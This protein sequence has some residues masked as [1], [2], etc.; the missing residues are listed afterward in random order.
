MELRKYILKICVSSQSR[1]LSCG[2]VFN[3]KAIVLC[4]GLW[5]VVSALRQFS[6]EKRHDRESHTFCLFYC[7]VNNAGMS[8]A[9]FNGL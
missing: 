9:L 7:F 1:R 2:A 3:V 5:A 4:C 6:D 8:A